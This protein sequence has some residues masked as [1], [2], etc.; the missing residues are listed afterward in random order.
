MVVRRKTIA[1]EQL[2]TTL[3]LYLDNPLGTVGENKIPGRGSCETSQMLLPESTVSGGN[4]CGT[5]QT[6]RCYPSSN[7]SSIRCRLPKETL[8]LNLLQFNK[9]GLLSV[10]SDEDYTSIGMIYITLYI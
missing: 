1:S 6:C 7:L 4:G 5:P 2:L 10:E 8:Q 9:G 3:K